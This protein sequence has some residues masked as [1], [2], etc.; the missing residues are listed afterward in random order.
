MINFFNFFLLL[1]SFDS[2][3]VD[4]PWIVSRIGNILLFFHSHKHWIYLH[5]HKCTKAQLDFDPQLQ[6][7]IE[8]ATI[9]S[10]FN[11]ET[12]QLR[13]VKVLKSWK[14]STKKYCRY[15]GLNSGL[16]LPI[17]SLMYLLLNSTTQTWNQRLIALTLP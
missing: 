9:K 1:S 6:S 17:M 12:I 14:F 13:S 4:I 8:Y 15:W 10:L 16:Q 2:A 3:L 5:E 11:I 7:V